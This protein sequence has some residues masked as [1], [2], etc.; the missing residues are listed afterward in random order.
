MTQESEFLIFSRNILVIISKETNK[1]SDNDNTRIDLLISSHRV[2]RKL[3]VDGDL[4]AIS[5]RHDKAVGDLDVAL[6]VRTE[7]STNHTCHLLVTSLVRVDDREEHSRV[8]FN[9]D[10]QAH[11]CFFFFFFLLCTCRYK[12]KTAMLVSINKKQ[13]L[14]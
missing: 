7:Q 4:I 10:W 3:D 14:Y 9:I 6:N 13:I 8:D 1:P 2:S 5:M 11:L 12:N